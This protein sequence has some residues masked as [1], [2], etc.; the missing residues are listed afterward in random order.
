MGARRHPS[1]SQLQLLQMQPVTS[2]DV[3][4][5]SACRPLLNCANRQT[6]VC[7]TR[8]LP[9]EQKQEQRDPQSVHEMPIDSCRLSRAETL[10][11]TLDRV[12]LPGGTQYQVTKR[13][14]AAEQMQSM[15]RR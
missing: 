9:K 1:R 2:E 4:Y 8:S 10:Q 15:R 3:P 5:A 7:R 12:A 6:E 11:F 13:E 14:Y